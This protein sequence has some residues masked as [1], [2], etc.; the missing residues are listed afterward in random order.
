MLFRSDIAIDRWN[1]AQL[2]QQMMTDGLSVVAFGQG[3][4]SMSPAAKDFESLMIS[5]KLRHSGHPVLRWCMGNCSIE[6]DAAGNIKPSKGRSSEKIDL[7]VASIMAVARARVGEA[8]GAKKTA[9]SVYE[10]R[11]LALL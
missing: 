5:Q 11:G 3:Y 7:L 9:P 1:C 2:A 6:S 8:G 10:S 4:A